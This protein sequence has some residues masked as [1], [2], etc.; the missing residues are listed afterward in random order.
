M[1]P[2]RAV[3]RTLGIILIAAPAL[4]LTFALGAALMR[5]WDRPGSPALPDA[6]SVITQMREVARLETLDVTL[7]KKISFEPGPAPSG[8]FWGD[9]AAWAKFNLLPTRG[10]AIVFAD[11]HLGLALDQLDMRH[12]RLSGRRAEVILPPLQ[13]TVSLRPA[14]TEVIQSNLDSKETTE[15]LELAKKAFEQEALASV[16]LRARARASSERALRS[17]LVSVGFSEVDFVESLPQS[18]NAL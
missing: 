3:R 7:F 17:L 16:P 5:L 9:V 14:D 10:K 6:P 12:L 8:S 18:Q 15:L 2:F 11:V 13:V 1:V 4:V